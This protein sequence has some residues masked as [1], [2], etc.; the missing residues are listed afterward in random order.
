M[1]KCVS[2]VIN[3]SCTNVLVKGFEYW[4]LLEEEACTWLGHETK[5]TWGSYDQS[6]LEGRR[7]WGGEGKKGRKAGVRREVW[8]HQQQLKKFFFEV[9]RLTTFFKL[10]AKK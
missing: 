8:G 1:H 4:K 9:T 5:S 3:F 10:F 6:V 7:E 2:N